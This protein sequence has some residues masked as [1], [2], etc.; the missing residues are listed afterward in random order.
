MRR[1]CVS[2]TSSTL[3]TTGGRPGVS[4]EVI[5]NSDGSL[6]WGFSVGFLSRSLPDDIIRPI[7]QDDLRRAIVKMRKS[8][9]AGGAGALLHAALD[10]TRLDHTMTSAQPAAAAPHADMPLLPACPSVSWLADGGGL[11]FF[12]SFFLRIPKSKIKAVCQSSL[13]RVRA[14][15][16]QASPFTKRSHPGAWSC[17]HHGHTR[18]PSGLVVTKCLTPDG[19]NSV[20]LWGEGW[21]GGEAR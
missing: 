2:A 4:V 13:S 5:N 1:C 9:T 17:W 18:R 11:F 10:W 15:G 12:S 19:R 21:D 7:H 20:W 6:R 3:R 16:S 8:K 14:A